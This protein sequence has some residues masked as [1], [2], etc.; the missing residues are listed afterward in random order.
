MGRLFATQFVQDSISC[1]ASTKEFNM[2]K[3]IDALLKALYIIA[4]QLM[5]IADILER[6]VQVK[7]V[8]ERR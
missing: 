5:R 2:F 1:R 3:R 8:K 7:R 6:E 4:K